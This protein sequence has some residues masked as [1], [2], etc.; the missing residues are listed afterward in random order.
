MPPLDERVTTLPEALD[1][2]WRD[3]RQALQAGDRPAAIDHLRH[4]RREAPRYVRAHLLYQDV[5]IDSGRADHVARE[6]RPPPIQDGVSL[7]LYARVARGRTVGGDDRLDSRGRIQLLEEAIGIEPGLAWAHYALGFE[8][9]RIQEFDRARDA[10]EQA[11][12]IDPDLPEAHV[13]LAGL[14]YRTGESRRA[15]QHYVAY[16]DRCPRD[17]PRWFR[18]A[19]LYQGQGRREQAE[20]CYRKVLDTDLPVVRAAIRTGAIALREAQLDRLE[21]RAPVWY[22]ARVNLSELLIEVGRDRDAVDVL[23]P[24]LRDWPE[25]PDAH[26]N[27]GIAYERLGDLES[28]HAHWENYLALGGTQRAR[29]ASWIEDITARRL[30]PPR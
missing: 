18:L 30:A 22:S 7:L 24:A 12:R 19:L 14:H 21:Q 11:V 5:M 20:S 6:Y 23:Q 9:E 26:Y 13:A 28:A 15:I 27:L 1:P 2:V 16:L 4:I 25:R 10:L 17:A 8:L 3:A 29:V